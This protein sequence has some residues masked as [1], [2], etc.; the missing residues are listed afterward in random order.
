MSEYTHN[1][2]VAEMIYAKD[3]EIEELKEI[4]KH[5]ASEI[6]RMETYCNGF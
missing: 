5:L 4:L 1:D 6:R 2:D 3:R